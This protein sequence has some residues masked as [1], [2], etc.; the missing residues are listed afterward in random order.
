MRRIWIGWALWLRGEWG[1]WG[2]CGMW[3]VCVCVGSW[4]VDGD[5]ILKVAILNSKY[6]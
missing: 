4:E 1:E 2:E 6:G 3:D 5:G